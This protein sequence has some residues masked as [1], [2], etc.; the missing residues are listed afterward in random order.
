M[1]EQ[2]TTTRARRAKREGKAGTTQAGEFVREEID[3]VREGKTQVK[4]TKQAIAI[5]LSKARRAGVKTGASK[6]ASKSTKKKIAQEEAKGGKQGKP[7]PTRSRGAKKA[8]KT[9]QQGHDGAQD[10]GQRGAVDADQARGEEAQRQQPLD[11]GEEGRADQGG[12]GAQGRGQEGGADPR[13]KVR[14]AH[15]L[16]EKEHGQVHVGEEGD[17]QKGCEQ[18][19]FGKEDGDEKDGLEED[20]VEEDGLEKVDRQEDT[21]EEER[22]QQAHDQQAR[23]QQDVVHTQAQFAHER[24]AAHDARRRTPPPRIALPPCKSPGVLTARCTW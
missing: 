9:R 11:G 3:R 24:L 1:P 21:G 23:G 17:G 5:G 15:V 10:R 7:S 16:R 6:T 20:C 4:S 19:V 14:Y 13:Q 18:G 12:D 2:S 22:L 8:L